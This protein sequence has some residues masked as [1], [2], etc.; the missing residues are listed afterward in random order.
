M[1]VCPPAYCCMQVLGASPGKGN[2]SLAVSCTYDP[3]MQVLDP[4]DDVM[5]EARATGRAL[6]SAAAAQRAKRGVVRGP[7]A[8]RHS[9][10]PH[11]VRIP[12]LTLPFFDF[13]LVLSTHLPFCKVLQPNFELP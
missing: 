8:P 4:A 5:L 7:P 6:M 13:P 12:G 11:S 2:V 1:Q 3:C 9:P 10:S